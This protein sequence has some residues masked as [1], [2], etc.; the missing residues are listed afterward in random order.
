[1]GIDWVYFSADGDEEAA[2]AERRSGGPL[3]L[4][5]QIGRRRVGLFRTVPVTAELGAGYPGFLVRGYDPVVNMAN[6]EA[7]LTGRDF[8]SVCA[9]P[10]LGAEVTHEP[11][12][13]GAGVVTLTD[14]LRDALIACE[15]EALEQ[16]VDRWAATEEFQLPGWEGVTRAEHLAFLTQLRTLA[17]ETRDTGHR[18]Y[19]WFQV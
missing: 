7:L 12:A 5:V 6:L 13:E 11:S 16:V 15:Q 19:C 4:P 18:L 3:G 14:S 17:T 1:M 8:D 2:E 10:R 9:E